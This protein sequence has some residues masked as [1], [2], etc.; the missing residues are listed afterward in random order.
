MSETQSETSLDDLSQDI[1]DVTELVEAISHQNNLILQR[2]ND[3]SNENKKPTIVQ[4]FE[5]VFSW[6]TVIILLVVALLVVPLF[7]EAL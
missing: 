1:V 7:R 4:L 6:E 2:L 3:A 5:T